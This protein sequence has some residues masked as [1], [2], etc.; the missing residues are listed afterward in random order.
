MQQVLTIASLQQLRRQYPNPTPFP[1]G[2][3]GLVARA[4][5]VASNR[6]TAIPLGRHIECT[7]CAGLVSMVSNQKR[8]SLASLSA[9]LVKLRCFSEAKWQSDEN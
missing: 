5:L 2:R 7:D 9:L 1:Q 6:S 8:V 4:P 3:V